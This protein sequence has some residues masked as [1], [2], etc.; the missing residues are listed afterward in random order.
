MK[1]RKRGIDLLS[2]MLG[3]CVIISALIGIFYSN[4]GTSFEVVNMYGDTVKIYGDGIYA[5]NSVFNV[6]NYFGS[7]ASGIIAATLLIFLSLWK[8]RPLWAD[9]LRTSEIVNLLYASA[10]SVFGIS[11]NQLY[12]LYVLC[13]GLAIFA[14][15]L[16]VNDL[17]TI[18]EVPQALK[19]K[20]LMGTAIFLMFSGTLTALVWLTSLLPAVQSGNFGT[21]L[22]IQTNE[23]TY[24]LDLSIV[25]PLCILCGIWLI[26]KKDIGYKVA[27]LLLNMLVGVAIM[28]VIQRAYCLKLGIE[29]PIQVLI[30]FV[31]S[32][33]L[34]GLI[35]LFFLV[36]LV[37]NLKRANV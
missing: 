33:V 29:L 26:K 17:F 22:G 14:S 15:F 30:S 34:L 19:E 31:I 3:I 25:C 1:K 21:L 11:M 7:N 28:V 10:C 12:F 9:I 27:P 4:G 18:I 35:A 16:A 2:I 36:K 37:T 20:K 5:Y 23:V 6:S 24:G 13:F 32:F 8:S